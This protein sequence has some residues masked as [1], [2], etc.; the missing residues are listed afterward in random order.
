M[1]KEI[2]AIAEAL[3]NERAIPRDKIFEALE[4]AL[5][6]ATKKDSTGICFI[7][8]RPFKSFLEQFV[9]DC[10][11]DIIDF[12][13][14]KVV[15]RHEG[16]H[17][18]TIGQRRGLN[19]GGM[20]KPCYVLG[21]DMKKNIVYIVRGEDHPLLYRQELVAR[22][23]NWFVPLQAPTTC[24]A[25]VRYRSPDEKCHVYPLEDGS[26]RVLFDTPVKAITPGQ[27]VAF[28]QGD[29][30]LGGGVIDVPMIHLQ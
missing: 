3:S 18:Y 14:Q 17:Y 5:A 4:T 21:K 15:G 23:L 11:G 2:I 30:C 27:T 16:A 24:S 29:I 20:E 6:T 28:Y 1:G 12:D 10:P 7:G 19:V 8:K 25:K 13:T 22:E 26:V 9:A